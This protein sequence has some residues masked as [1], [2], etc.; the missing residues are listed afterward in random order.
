MFKC[1]MFVE[2]NIILK[3]PYQKKLQALFK[4]TNNKFYFT[5]HRMRNLIVVLVNEDVLERN[6]SYTSRQKGGKEG[7][8]DTLVC[9][10]RL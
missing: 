7:R 9:D 3:V 5:C 10:I 8:E 1:F 4:Y 2:K 6:T